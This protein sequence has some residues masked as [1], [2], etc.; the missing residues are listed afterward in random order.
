M[1]ASLPRPSRPSQGPPTAALPPLPVSKTRKSTGNIPTVSRPPSDPEAPAV[2]SSSL[3]Q[4]PSSSHLP[5]SSKA[6]GMPRPTLQSAAATS[7]LPSIDTTSASSIPGVNVTDKAVRRTI[8][9]AAFPHPPNNGSRISS[10]PPSPL[11]ATAV[12]RS[13]D[14]NSRAPAGRRE[15]SEKT[16]PL[17][18]AS[19]SRL[20]RTK[21]MN[22]NASHN[23]T[24][25]RTPS[26]LNGSGDAKSI[27]AGIGTRSSDALLNIASPAG[28]R[29][30]SA[31]GSSSTSATTIDDSGDSG[32][33]GRGGVMDS[34]DTDQSNSN[35]KE[36]KGNVIVSVRVR[37]DNGGENG[38]A[39]G[40]WMVDGR[41]SLVAYRGREGGDYYYGMFRYAW[42]SSLRPC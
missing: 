26:L 3:R 25:S 18:P 23:Y 1:A 13:A 39:D 32:P 11:S 7:K 29:T 38:R 9:V 21:T 4:A 2:P 15:S 19:T 17:T 10:L 6:S 41:R 34:N 42:P 22:S 31:Q 30:S 37:P 16:S 27:S 28:S 35:P 5:T 8:S 12:S 36:G 33:R 20:K 24:G 14:A 40:E